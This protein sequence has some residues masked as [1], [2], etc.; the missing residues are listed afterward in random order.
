MRSAHIA[1]DLASGNERGDRV[2]NDDIHGAGTYEGIAHFKRG[3]AVVGLR[4]EQ[5]VYVHA[6]RL[7][8]YG[9]ER[10]LGVDEHGGAAVFLHL[11]Y[12]M[13]RDR[14]LTGRFRPEYLYYPALGDA[15]YAECQVERKTARGNGFDFHVGVVAE[16]HYDAFA[17][18]FFELGERGLQ[19]FSLVFSAYIVFRHDLYLP[20]LKFFKISYPN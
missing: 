2:D 16:T 1:F 5:V 12:H 18:L 3:L 14:G 9:V 20:L 6:Q 17:F 13:Q 19:R 4:N 15:A 10:V 8:V 7:S 11:G